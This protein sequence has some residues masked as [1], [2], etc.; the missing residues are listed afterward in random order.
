MRRNTLRRLWA[1]GHCAVNAWLAIPAAYSAEGLSHQ[2][3]DAVTVDLQH[4]MIDAQTAISMLQAISTSPAVPL[5]RVGGM[6]PV[7]IMKMLDAGAYGIICPMISTQ[8]EAE[9]FVDACRYP[10]AGHRSF[11]PA[12]GLLYGGSDYFQ[13]ANEEILT[14]A[15]VETVE[16]VNNIDAICSVPGLDAI[17]VG[18][19]DLCLDY[20]EAPTSEPQGGHAAAAIERVQTRTAAAGKYC[21]IFCSGGSAARMRRQQG[22]SLVT[23]GNDMGILLKAAKAEIGKIRSDIDE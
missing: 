6:D 17:Y 10:P 14:I 20:G 7:A 2:G 9:R 18:P 23:P 1:D 12:R 4:G 13:Y 11:G 3:Y 21:G 8:A 22:F 5:V 15:M 19:N 16:G